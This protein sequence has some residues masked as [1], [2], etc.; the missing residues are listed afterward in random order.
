MGDIE[1]F[2]ENNGI[3]VEV[4]MSGG[5][6][7]TM[8]EV[9]PISRHLEEFSKKSDE[10]MCYFIAPNIYVDSVKQIEYVK[11]TDNIN[12]KAKSIEDFIQHLESSDI[13]FSN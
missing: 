4:T 3:L 11:H 13:L 2:E 9:W 6:A 10:S 1:C 7:Q 8:M 5:R 12:I